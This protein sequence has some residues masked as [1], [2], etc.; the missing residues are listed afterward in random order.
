MAEDETQ[1]DEATKE[2]ERA[3]AQAAHGADRE[4]AADEADAAE[5]ARA[6]LGDEEEEAG[7]HFKEMGDIGSQVQGEGRI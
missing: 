4:P 6:Q 1:P 7:A 2:A 3:E 5:K